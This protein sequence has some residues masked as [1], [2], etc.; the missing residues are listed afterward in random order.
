[1]ALSREPVPSI[2][3][4]LA[5]FLFAAVFAI[6]AAL[7]LSKWLVLTVVLVVAV[8]SI[9]CLLLVLKRKKVLADQWS[10]FKENRERREHRNRRDLEKVED[11][12]FVSRMPRGTFGFEETFAV[13]GLQDGSARPKPR[14]T[15]GVGK[16]YRL[17]IHRLSDE[18]GTLQIVGYASPEEDPAERR[19]EYCCRLYMRQDDTHSRWVGVPVDRIKD[20]YDFPIHVDL[21]LMR[22][23]T[24][25]SDCSENEP[26]RR[27]VTKA[28][29]QL[30]AIPCQMWSSSEEPADV[31]T[32]ESGRISKAS[33]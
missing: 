33:G 21:E 9:V 12:L 20:A 31:L 24:I 14:E 15:D 1:M 25:R 30:N 5:G 11:E 10:L 4:G 32:N 8:G 16:Q 26:W 28:L 27:R 23:D 6:I 2:G 18:D 19:D 29:S 17:E 13:K 3:I 22:I 7:P